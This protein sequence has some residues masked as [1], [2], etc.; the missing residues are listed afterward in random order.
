MG[1][2]CFVRVAT[3]PAISSN[4]SPKVAAIGATIAMPDDNSPNVVLPS[5]TVWNI[6]SATFLVSSNGSLKAFM[7]VVNPSTA[8][9]VSVIPAIPAFVA[10]S[11][12][13]RALP[14][15]TPAEI[16]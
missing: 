7:T 1:A 13:S 5:F 14:S 9:A 10:I 4:L 15:G 2:P 6:T 8:V 12:K 11:K 3:A 16:V